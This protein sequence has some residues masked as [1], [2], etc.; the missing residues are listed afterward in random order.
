MIS[1][2]RWT[3]LPNYIPKQINKVSFSRL[4]D[5][6]KCKK[7]AK[8]KYIDK[9]PEPDRPLPPGKTEH[10]N[11]RGTRIHD[12]A[13][14]FVRGGVELIEEL[15]L[16]SEE[17]HELRDLFEEGRVQLE[18]E[19][20][21]DLDWNP[22]AW[23]SNDAWCR[24]KLDAMVLSEDG[25]H[26]R[27]IDYKTGRR[28]GNEI[29]HTEQG[30]IYQ[31]STFLRFPEVQDITVEFWY[32]DQDETDIKR[33]TRAQGTSYFD[34]YNDRLLAVTNC[35]DFPP[36][37]NAFSCKWCPYNGN[38]CKEGVPSTFNKRAKQR[39]AAAKKQSRL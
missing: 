32:T 25:T 28:H 22:V 29:K 18:G 8:L 10:A 9:V 34:K 36:N 6:E 37:P 13:E 39:L 27:V 23:N 2:S 26:A 30:Q 16:F 20:A 24:M 11:D 35:V 7:L 3:S 31:L 14:L 17:F 21:V 1:H 33:Y 19:W 5:F 4:Q 12:A 15:E 38:E